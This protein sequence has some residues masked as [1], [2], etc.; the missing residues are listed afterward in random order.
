MAPK[1][2]AL[3]IQRRR[4]QLERRAATSGASRDGRSS[5]DRRSGGR[6]W[7][8]KPAYTRNRDA[9]HNRRNIR[10]STPIIRAGYPP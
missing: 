4:K 10:G 6:I 5:G 2:A 3:R 8:R 9:S 1:T 7:A